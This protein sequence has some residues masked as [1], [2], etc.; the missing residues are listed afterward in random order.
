MSAAQLVRADG[1]WQRAVNV[2]EP[3]VGSH[4]LTQVITDSNRG[5]WVRKGTE[6]LFVRDYMEV[7]ST[8]VQGPYDKAVLGPSLKLDGRNGSHG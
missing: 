8:A 2:F 7:H 4:V 1:S 6:T 3:V 5:F